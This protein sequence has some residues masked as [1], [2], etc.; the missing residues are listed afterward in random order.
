MLVKLVFWGLVALDTAGL[1]LFFVLGL[2]A[3]GS[4]KTNPLSVALYLLILPAIPLAL[5]VFA[6]TRGTSPLMRGLAFVLVAAPLLVAVG[7]KAYAVAEFAAN[8]NDKGELTF[9]K[10]GTSRDIVEAIRRNDAATVAALA[11]KVDINATGMQDMTL[12]MAAL[13][14]LRETP[15]QHEVL[16]ALLKAGADP[17]K[18]TKFEQPLSMALQV[19]AKGGPEPVLLLLD[20]GANPNLKDG[21]GTPLYFGAAGHDIHPDVLNAMFA[22][23]ADI[24]A[25]GPQGERLLFYAADARNWRVVKM[26]LE[27]GVDPKQGKTLSGQTFQ[28]MLESNESWMRADSGYADVMAILRKR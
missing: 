10:A 3:A 2:A 19:A 13:Q 21:F 11:P 15:E 26:L 7:T 16:K 12:L 4:S 25:T 23:G 20:A 27:R 17:N 8:T 18:G 24:N 1:L 28:E 22:H 5:S 9:F 14:Q 6:F